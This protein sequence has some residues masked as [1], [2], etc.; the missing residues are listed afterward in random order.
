M[1][2]VQIASFD[3]PSPQPLVTR[4]PQLPPDIVHLVCAH[5]S[6]DWALRSLVSVAL[7]S[8]SCHEAA[9]PVLGDTLLLSLD[10]Q[11]MLLCP[12]AGTARR[13]SRTLRLLVSPFS[14]DGRESLA[15]R[16]LRRASLP[17]LDRLESLSFPLPACASTAPCSTHLLPDLLCAPGPL[18]LEPHS[19]A[20]A[21]LLPPTALNH[22]CID[23]TAALAADFSDRGPFPSLAQLIRTR[24]RTPRFTVHFD[25][26][27]RGQKLARVPACT[28]AMIIGGIAYPP[29]F[30]GMVLS[31]AARELSGAILERAG[32]GPGEVISMPEGLHKAAL[33]VTES[34]I[35]V[36][37]SPAVWPVVVG[38]NLSEATVD[39]LRLAV[40]KDL[41][42]H[43]KPS[44][45]TAGVLD[46]QTL[47]RFEV[48]GRCSACGRW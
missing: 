22:V 7:A 19:P 17:S 47:F 39:Q 36:D 3:Q 18:S 2:A 10:Q 33:P 4:S 45:G 38:W 30:G 42:R 46:F 23:G 34:V 31:E 9:V 1:A 32:L 43:V 24:T 16:M 5:L 14:S 29:L 6:A 28:P 41:A 25:D 40:S 20:L 35:Q 15:S 44:K 21:G 27:T 13:P 37:S 26:T 11:E 12:A 8:R 48:S